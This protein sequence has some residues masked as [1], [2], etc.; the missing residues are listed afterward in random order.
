MEL[1]REASE[2]I[3]P[4]L[5][6]EIWSALLGGA[7]SAVDQ[8][9]W[10]PFY[11]NLL[12]APLK[13]R[14]QLG[15][16]HLLGHRGSSN[17][18]ATP[19][20]EEDILQTAMVCI[21]GWQEKHQGIRGGESHSVGSVIARLERIVRAV[22]TANP[23]L[24]CATGLGVLCQPIAAVF[25]AEEAAA[26]LAAQ[27]IL[28]G[29]L[30]PLYGRDGKAQRRHYLQLFGALLGFADPILALHLQE[31][32][33]E[34]EAYASDWFSTWFAQLL[35]QSQAVRL[36]DA[37]LLRP[38]Q[39]SLFVGVCLVHFFRLSLLA[40]EEASHV[41][42][43]LAS[44]AQLVDCQV[45][46]SSAVALFQATPASVTL[47]VFPRHS[48]GEALLWEHG[49]T[50]M[51]AA[52]PD[53]GYLDSIS[54]DPCIDPKIDPSGLKDGETSPHQQLLQHATEQWRQCEWWRQ[55]INNS[56]TPPIIT[57]DDLLSFRSCCYVLD[58][59]SSEEFADCHF[60]SSIHVKDADVLDLL[61]TLPQELVAQ[62]G[63]PS[64]SLQKTSTSASG[65]Q[66]SAEGSA[67]ASEPLASS[68]P[69][70]AP[71]WLGKDLRPRLVVVVGG[72]DLGTDF[73]E[74]LRSEG[75][76]GKLS[77]SQ[78]M[79]CACWAASQRFVRKRPGTISQR[80]YALLGVGCDSLLE[81][82]IV[83]AWRVM[84]G[85][86][87]LRQHPKERFTWSFCNELGLLGLSHAVMEL[88][89]GSVL[90]R[91]AVVDPSRDWPV[92][93]AQCGLPRATAVLWQ[94][95]GLV[96]ANL[97]PQIYH[98]NAVLNAC[99]RTGDW[100]FA[101]DHL[102]KIVQHDLWPNKFSFSA[103]IS[104]CEKGNHWQVALALLAG[105][106]EW[107]VAADTV[108]LNTA[109]S[110]CGKS[111]Q[112]EAA[113]H[114][115]HGMHDS[116]LEADAVSFNA[117]IVACRNFWQLASQLLQ[118]ALV[119]HRAV[120]NNWNAAASTQSW[121]A[122]LSLL[123]ALQG[124]RAARDVVSFSA[125]FGAL[126]V[127]KRWPFAGRALQQMR[128][129]DIDSDVVCANAAANACAQGGVWQAAWSF[130]QD[131][132][133]LSLRTDQGLVSS[134]ISGTR[135][136]AELDKEGC[137][138]IFALRILG[139]SQDVALPP[140]AV[141][142]SN[143]LCTCGKSAAWEASL[144]LFESL[145]LTTVEPDSVCHTVTINAWQAGDRWR[146]ASVALEAM[147]CER[148]STDAFAH[149]AALYGGRVGAAWAA[150]SAML[151]AMQSGGLRASAPS[152]TA[153]IGH[154]AREGQWLQAVQYFAKVQMQQSS[155]EATSCCVAIR[156]CQQASTWDWALAALSA[157]RDAD[158]NAAALGACRNGRQ[159]IRSAS[160]LMEMLAFAVKLDI[161][162]S[163]SAASAASAAG[164]W[165][166]ALSLLC[167]AATSRAVLDEKSFLI[168]YQLLR[169]SGQEAL[170]LVLDFEELASAQF[171][172]FMPWALASMGGAS[173]EDMH[174]TM[175]EAAAA[176]RREAPTP[177]ALASLWWS[178]SMLG[179]TSPS[180][181]RTLSK[182]ARQ[183]VDA[184]R[185]SELLMVLWG[186]CGSAKDQQ[187]Q[188]AFQ[189]EAADR[190]D[191][192]DW[193]SLPRPMQIAWTLDCLGSLWACTFSRTLTADAH[194]R[195][196]AALLRFG[197]M[198]DRIQET[199]VPKTPGRQRLVHDESQPAIVLDAWDSVVLFK[200]ADYEVHDENSDLPQLSCFMSAMFCNKLPI[201]HDE[202]HEHG[203][204]H[205]LDVPS[206]GLILAAK[207][208][209]CYYDL[210]VQLVTG[211]ILRDS[212]R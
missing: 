56:P 31:L 52:D 97:R 201:L 186:A 135:V 86:T 55:R 33:M 72:E 34:P 10:A 118:D 159:W 137:A 43:F 8:A 155:V 136:D 191:K 139:H 114:L 91:S 153:A 147:P 126:G 11:E 165:S 167:H 69:E 162:S 115:L 36:W 41:A 6:S 89:S 190:L 7:P 179:V 60:Q 210:Q 148:L 128:E 45:L 51:A 37:L 18:L 3:P 85:Q 125:L 142:R 182:Y 94:L 109:I 70:E 166:R 110:A 28:H 181:A 57:V 197:G 119:G 131:L 20:A 90:A 177:M 189:R 48:A 21:Q 111:E 98:L 47:P 133:M 12:T 149:G 144:R 32:G 184:F 59:R 35:P 87:F 204:L 123:L 16:A 108:V 22:L 124:A 39:F 105:M 163:T 132:C 88:A 53:W 64:P 121:E 26:F 42:S 188:L 62:C 205:R 19:A 158:C 50:A 107:K 66:A 29:F 208:F 168:T 77:H 25:G 9:C 95:E 175:A 58:A 171:V 202:E 106:P 180:F 134:T 104:A 82:W 13:S 92:M 122:A 209:E 84:E 157:G 74:R 96:R 196:R 146:H 150:A 38:P 44:C 154:L 23:S 160:L 200:P 80:A 46:V 185:F 17:A 4:A 169:Q 71:P 40:L 27:R 172:S 117:A 1:F 78:G 24:R 101:V 15:H 145:Q 192:L 211:Q 130:L 151:H 173:A 61:R 138:W 199:I 164:E 54:M 194:H 100:R 113:L 183:Q 195:I 152:D 176:I 140:S 93:V 81:D 30:W 161:A 120:V 99:G 75:I 203:F 187:V 156:A 207:S 63:T 65:V 83:N 73:A 198:L 49:S 206:S 178:A 2:D 14:D 116:L 174:G 170:G 112:W 67:A 129:K 79:W 76:P 141:S 193:A 103:A 102:Q 143:A 5:R 127:G 68:S 212:C